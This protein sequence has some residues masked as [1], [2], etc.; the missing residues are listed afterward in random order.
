MLK[1][2]VYVKFGIEQLNDDLK[3][4]QTSTKQSR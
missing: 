1:K 4:E 3:Y 2:I